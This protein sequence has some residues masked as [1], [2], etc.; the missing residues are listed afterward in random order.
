MKVLSRTY[1]QANHNLVAR[2]I[3]WETGYC[4]LLEMNWDKKKRFTLPGYMRNSPIT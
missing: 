1:D 3:V 2:S 4:F